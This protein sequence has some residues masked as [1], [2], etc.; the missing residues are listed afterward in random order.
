V[1][2]AEKLKEEILK[3][4]EKQGFKYNPHIR[5][6]GKSK[7]TLRRVQQ[8]SRLEQLE[9]HKNLLKRASAKVKPFI[10]NGVD[11]DPTKIDLSLREIQTGSSDAYIFNWWNLVWWRIPYQQPYGRQMRYLIWDDGHDAPF[12]LISLQS[13][14]LRMSVRDEF[15]EVPKDE[16]DVWIN[17]SLQAQRI[18]AFPPYNYL[19]GGKMCALAIVCNE[20]RDRYKEKYSERKT[21]LKNREISSDLLF[22]TTTSAFGRS[23]VYNRLRHNNQAV[24]LS[25]GYTKGAGSFHISENLY[26]QLID[27][28][29]ER[30]FE[31]GREFGN[32]PS[33]K[34]KLI[35]K[36]LSELG[37]QNGVYHNVLREFFLFPLVTNLKKVI[38][39]GANPKYH[40]RSFN[41]LFKAWKKNYAIPRSE[42]ETVA[43]PWNK[44]D[45]KAFFR[46]A[47]K[48]YDP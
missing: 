30:G 21:I 32:G 40:N 36:G 43:F 6:S 4:L 10:R 39:N 38:A 16:L 5:P 12:G 28:L 25:L 9:L 15:L 23:S 27:L 35:R 46:K 20:I 13:P 45:G 8:A 44:F 18:G 26:S 29:D 1:V 33:R 47:K 14:V 11:I 34:M 42:R 2:N 22:L 48:S 24:A 41:T 19:L 3:N 31:T 7:T 37:I 17:R